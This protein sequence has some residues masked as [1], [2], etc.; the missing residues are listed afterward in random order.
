MF[1]KIITY[2]VLV[3]FCFQFMFCRMDDSETETD[4]VLNVTPT[5][6][7]F[8]ANESE[9]AFKVDSRLRMAWHID[10]T[11]S[12]E[13]L[14]VRTNEKNEMFVVVDKNLS[15]AKRS[16]SLEVV[17]SN[18]KYQ[19]VI[20]VVQVT[21]EASLLESSKDTITLYTN[22]QSM[23]FTITA[24]GEWHFDNLPDWISV[25]R[26]DSVND[27]TA[28]EV[29]PLSTNT[30][31][32][33]RS[34]LISVVF[35]LDT[36]PIFVQQWGN[37]EAHIYNESRQLQS[38]L[39]QD[40]LLQTIETLTLEGGVDYSDFEALHQIG[41]LRILDLLNIEISDGQVNLPGYTLKSNLSLEEV[42]MPKGTT[43]LSHGLFMDCTMLHKVTLS[44]QVA[45]V[46]ELV[47]AG[48]RNLVSLRLP[49]SVTNIDAE[50]FKGCAI[51]E[52]I[53]DSE[54]PPVL[55]ETVFDETTFENCI[56]TVPKG[57]L[58][59]YKAERDW[60]RFLNMKEAD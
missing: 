60:M 25:Q 3:V 22:R 13:W 33:A 39:S 54:T 16:S 51:K 55:G 29:V 2:S 27:K 53:L 31:S 26:V 46:E 49:K 38:I 35:G 24:D 32:G 58:E 14:H 40:G 11:L 37:I 28:V 41:K 50:A 30:T 18:K 10:S 56:V 52:L 21:G 20:T 34:Q 48:C 1:R 19:K 42:V 45:V 59:A 5:E 15:G 17:G 57:S 9:K 8:S 47:F 43:T 36:K 44:D 6:M 7:T 12:A 4:D 23:Q